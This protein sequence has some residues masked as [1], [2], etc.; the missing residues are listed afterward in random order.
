MEETSKIKTW[1]V[2][3]N[4]KC[5]RC[6]RM[7]RQGKIGKQEISTT[8]PSGKLT[9]S[10]FIDRAVKNHGDL[11]DYSESIYL[12]EKKLI[13]IRCIKHDSYFGK[14]PENHIFNSQGCPLCQL[15]K[16]ELA[17]LVYLKSH[18]I[19]YTT[20]KTFND[21]KSDK[22]R[23]LKFDFHVPFYNLLIE[24]DGAQHSGCN[25]IKG[26]IISD[27][28]L[29]RLKLHDELKNEY[30]AKNNIKLLR[31]SYKDIKKHQF[32]LKP[33]IKPINIIWDEKKYI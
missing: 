23:H 29:N 16:G 13:Q 10:E 8:T 24:F 4:C 28:K 7:T 3:P 20:Q 25:K 9:L 2:N 5:Q 32:H 26:H 17:I 33:T 15:S 21:L 6:R 14:T 30:A 22:N 1:I 31:I 11:C 12:G 19:N 18:N 27:Y